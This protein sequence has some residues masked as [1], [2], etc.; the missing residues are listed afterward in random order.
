MPTE[1][2]RTVLEEGVGDPAETGDTLI[3]DYVGVRSVDGVEF[4]NSYDREPFP[5]TLGAGGVIQGWE[6]GLLGAKQGE[7]VQ[8]DI[9]SALAYGEAARS[10][11]IRENEDLSFVIDVRSVQPHLDGTEAHLLE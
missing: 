4:D 1:L 6:D 7:R 2:V 8:L 9:P 10:D 11:V 3:V 5:I